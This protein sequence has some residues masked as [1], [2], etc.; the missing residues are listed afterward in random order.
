MGSD[1]VLN[2][3]SAVS[4][5]HGS[6]GQCSAGCKFG[7]ETLPTPKLFHN[8]YGWQKLGSFIWLESPAGVGFSY[9]DYDGCTANDTSTAVDNHNVLKAF[10][11]GFPEYASNDFYITGE[12]YAGICESNLLPSSHAHCFDSYLA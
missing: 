3:S 5:T 1:G 2:T 7:N 12:S 4:C 6:L 9:C 10:F 8:E 11:K